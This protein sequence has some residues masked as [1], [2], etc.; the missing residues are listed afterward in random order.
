MG[1]VI[2]TTPEVWKRQPNPPKVDPHEV[3]IRFSDRRPLRIRSFINRA[4]AE[5]ATLG[6]F[7]KVIVGEGVR[8]PTDTATSLAVMADGEGPAE[9][10]VLVVPRK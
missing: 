2:R 8:I 1:E 4:V 7:G 5:A 6:M 9:A 3:V 10:E